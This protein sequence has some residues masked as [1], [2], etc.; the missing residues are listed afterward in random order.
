MAEA[1]KAKAMVMRVVNCIVYVEV[2]VCVEVG[3]SRALRV[4]FFLLCN[5]VCFKND[6]EII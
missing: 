1:V 2:G 4:E 3:G 5:G 6:A